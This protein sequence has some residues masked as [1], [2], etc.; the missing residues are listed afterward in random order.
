MNFRW[1]KR[2]QDLRQYKFGGMKKWEKYD[3]LRD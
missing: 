3:T 2:S 1:N